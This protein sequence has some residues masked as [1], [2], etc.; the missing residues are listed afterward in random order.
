MYDS[1]VHTCFS[2]DSDTPPI[3]HLERAKDAGLDGVCFTDH[4]DLEFPYGIVF[5]LDYAARDALLDTLHVEGVS[6]T[7]GIELGLRKE[8]RLIEEN[9]RFLALCQPDFVLG[10]AH[11]VTGETDP[12][13]SSFFDGR[14]RAE[15][16]QIYLQ[17][18]LDCIRLF[19]A[20]HALGH[21]DYPSKNCPFEENGLR[22]GDAPE[23]IDEIL[24]LLISRGQGFEINTSVLKKNRSP[25]TDILRRYVELGGEWVVLG[26]DAHDASALGQMFGVARELAKDAG[27]RY[28]A[29]F[30]KGAPVFERI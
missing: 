30:V 8:A 26:S 22:H 5:D 20:F 18:V 19:D 4:L 6:F 1:H 15:G 7:R 25:H 12:Y 28:L 9:R 11:V 10:S 17:E 2:A 14:T 23:I 16:Y 21:M 29:H 3:A 13:Y 27:I 24:R